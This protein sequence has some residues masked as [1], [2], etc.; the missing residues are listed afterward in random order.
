[1]K[2][3]TYLLTLTVLAT[4]LP[5]CYKDRQE[6]HLPDQ[7]I[8]LWTQTSFH[9]KAYKGSAIIEEYTEAA[10]EDK[11]ITILFYKNGTFETYERNRE[12]GRWVITEQA[13]GTC[14]YLPD[15]GALIME[16]IENGEHSEANVLTLTS[17]QLTISQ[18]TS[19]ASNNPEADRETFTSDFKRGPLQ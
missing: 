15:T 1:M 11:E 2:K 7:I 14:R 3:I 16:D 17:Q 13:K 18:S 8:G 19:P 4:T 5:S 9:Y 6:T 10:S 12:D